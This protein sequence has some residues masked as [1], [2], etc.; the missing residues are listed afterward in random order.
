DGGV[1]DV[2]A[3]QSAAVHDVDVSANGDAGGGGCVAVV[4]GTSVQLLGQIN[5]NGNGSSTGSGGGCGG[6]GCFMARFGDFSVAGT[7]MAEGAGPE[8]GGGCLA[9]SARH[10]IMVQP[11]ALVSVRSNGAMGCGGAISLDATFDM[12]SD[13]PLDASGGFGG[14]FIDTTA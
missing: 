11:A 7:L 14:G 6:F 4:G 8:G 5:E 9:F 10:S 2:E 12:L 3:G 1:L 13:G